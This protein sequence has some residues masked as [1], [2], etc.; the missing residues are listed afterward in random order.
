M[1]LADFISQLNGTQNN[2]HFLENTVSSP[3]I[4]V[5]DNILIL[6]FGMLESSWKWCTKFVQTE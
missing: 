2:H 1:F 5:L 3:S 4:L 6:L